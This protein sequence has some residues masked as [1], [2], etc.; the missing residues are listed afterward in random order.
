MLSFRFDWGPKPLESD[1][2]ELASYILAEDQSANQYS[3][4]KGYDRKGKLDAM[5]STS[6]PTESLLEDNYGSQLQVCAS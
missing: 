1:N 4:A 2:K 5:L 6:D 3:T